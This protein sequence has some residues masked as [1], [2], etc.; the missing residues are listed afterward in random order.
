MRFR[1]VVYL[2]LAGIGAYAGWMVYRSLTEIPFWEGD[3]IQLPVLGE[4]KVVAIFF[5]V[6]FAVALPLLFIGLKDVITGP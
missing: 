1:T 5:P 2:A 3:V 4:I 6:A